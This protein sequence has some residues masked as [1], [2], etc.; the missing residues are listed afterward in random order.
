MLHDNGRPGPARQ[1]HGQRRDQSLVAADPVDV[2]TQCFQQRL[3]DQAVGRSPPPQGRLD[4]QLS[5]GSM[6][7][8]SS[9]LPLALLLVGLIGTQAWAPSATARQVA[10]GFSRHSK[11][12]RGLTYGDRYEGD[13]VAR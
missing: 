9:P 3:C 6:T 5:Y 13:C 7:R 2:G 12:R 1:D 11:S 4:R 10:R 8:R